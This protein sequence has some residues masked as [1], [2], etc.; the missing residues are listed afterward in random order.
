MERCLLDVGFPEHTARYLA[1]VAT[2]AGWSDQDVA[3]LCEVARASHSLNNPLGFITA[4][5]KNGQK[6][7]P[8]GVTNRPDKPRRPYTCPKCHCY[9]CICEWDF[10]TETLQEFKRRVYQV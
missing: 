5:I 6:E 4:R 2:A 8:N 7:N 10:A 1:A 3:D 9:P